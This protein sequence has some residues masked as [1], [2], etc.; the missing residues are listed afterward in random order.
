MIKLYIFLFIAISSAFAQPAWVNNPSIDGYLTGVGISN[1]KNPVSKR[2]MATVSARA[3]LA[4]TIK[5][6]ITSYFKMTTKT[7]NDSRSV[8]TNSMIEQKASEVLV[9][10]S[11]KDTY[12]DSDGN[13][14]VLVV[15]NKSS[16]KE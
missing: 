5:V 15:V 11:I 8:I 13:F 6:E 2:R 12:Q 16:I 10:S 1:D 4:E 3:N 9:E 14:Y 7:H